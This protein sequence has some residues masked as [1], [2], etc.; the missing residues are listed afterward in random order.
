MTTWSLDTVLRL[1]AEAGS[2]ALR[3]F[4]RPIADYKDDDTVVT[5]ADREI[6]QFFGASFDRPDEGSYLIGEETL[7]GRTQAYLQ[8]A[9]QR[10]AWVVDPIDGTILYAN[11]LSDWGISVGF[12]RDGV[13]SEGAVYFPLAGEIFVSDSGRNFTGKLD[14]RLPDASKQAASVV[15]RPV[16]TRR[17]GYAMSGIVAIPY[18]MMKHHIVPFKNPVFSGGSAVYPLVSLLQG[19][20][21][22][23]VGQLSLWDMAGSLP[24]L[25]NAGA[26]MTLEDGTPFGRSVNASLY[27][28]E[29]DDSKLFKTRGKLVIA[30]DEESHLRLRE[31]LET[32]AEPA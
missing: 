29:P 26:V 5:Q 10:V 4:E 1:C 21:M 18:D 23:F 16:E 31:E 7:A 22:G 13:L 27:H 3:H 32:I 24:L 19:R 8:T 2:I 15:L 28:L 14:P 12:M 9:L 17:G 30:L 25:W 11:H 6:E 20:M